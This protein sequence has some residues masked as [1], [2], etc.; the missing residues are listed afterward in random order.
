MFLHN[1]S[2][3]M[4]IA[5]HFFKPFNMGLMAIFHSIIKKFVL[6]LKK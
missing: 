3:E 1:L 2:S 5:L 4:A 6:K